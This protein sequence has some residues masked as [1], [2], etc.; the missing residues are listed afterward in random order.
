MWEIPS[1]AEGKKADV[2]KYSC[3]A[4]RSSGCSN[5]VLLHGVGTKHH[6]AAWHRNGFC[7]TSPQLSLL[8]GAAIYTHYL[9]STKADSMCE[10]EQ[11]KNERKKER[12][13]RRNE[14]NMTKR[15]QVPRTQNLI[16]YLT[17]M[18]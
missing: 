1:I 18:Q 5:S 2:V 9:C 16:N 3:V 14:Y 11:R 4:V 6:P 12:K 13:K 8:K 17:N 7:R 10:K 15:R